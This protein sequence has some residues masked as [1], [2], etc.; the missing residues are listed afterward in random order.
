MDNA[1]G[2][3]RKPKIH[4]GD[5]AALP[6]SKGLASLVDLPIWS[7]WQAVE[8]EKDG[9]IRVMKPPKR[10]DGRFANPAH[11]ETFCGLGECLETYDKDQELPLEERKF[12]G[13]GLRMPEWLLAIDCDGCMEYER[14]DTL[15]PWVRA[16]I[17]RLRSYCEI[18]PSAR[19]IRIFVRHSGERFERTKFKI[20]EGQ[21]SIE[22]YY[23]SNHFVTVTNS[24]YPGT[25]ARIAE[26]RDEVISTYEELAKAQP[27]EPTA[28]VYS[29]SD[30][31]KKR[32]RPSNAQ[33]T[34]SRLEK[35]IQDGEFDKFPS[36]SEA[37][38]YVACELVRR[39]KSD[40]EI[41][42]ILTDPNNRISEP[43]REH[44][45]GPKDQARKEVESAH[46]QIRKAQEAVESALLEFV[47]YSPGNDFIYSKTGDHWAAIAVDNEVN[48]VGVISDSKGSQIRPSS[49]I[50]QNRS[51][52]TLAWAP[53]LPPLVDGK[54]MTQGG[55]YEAEGKKT[56][57]L[58]RPPQIRR[59]SGP[60]DR[61]LGLITD[62]YG[63]EATDR[64]TKYFAHRVQCPGSK[65]SF[66]L[67]LGGKPGI[68]KDTLISPLRSAVG[69]WNFNVISPKDLFEPWTD[70]LRSVVLLINEAA[71]QG[72]VNRFML[73]EH[74]KMIEAAPPDV[75]RVN[76]K[77]G[78]RHFI[79]N[80]CGVIITTNHRTSALYLPSDDR[81]HEV[82]WS[83]KEP[84]ELEP[85]WSTEYYGWYESGGYGAIA[86]YLAELDLSG[87]SV[88]ETPQK[89]PAFWEMVA[90][91]VSNEDSQLED[92]LD[93]LG[94]PDVLTVQM[95]ISKADLKFAAWLDDH[96]KNGRTIRHRLD[97]AGYGMLRNPWNK[98]G[99][100][101]VGSRTM[102]LYGK[103]SVDPAVLLEKARLL[104]ENSG[105]SAQELL[106]GVF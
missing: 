61:W 96:H 33:R 39:G 52:A 100:W 95:L 106:G 91:G 4:C 44:A 45:L 6:Q 43:T 93:D 104:Q 28:K 82:Y 86:N 18:T 72:E 77:Y 87:Y 66:A 35:T 68:G 20:P 46:R 14:P 42:A 56:W 74:L 13:V 62:R 9:K 92:V 94:H 76:P 3:S 17:D 78:A 60:V 98:K 69:E 55:W 63:E 85:K 101:R 15:N 36:R 48:Q 75:L 50:M 16:L 27:A 65:P 34:D 67:V 47:Y 22:I 103:R 89:T 29:F 11:P 25:L 2:E 31:A 70:Y 21:G 73:Y 97:E 51:V 30:Q 5:L 54:L 84:E 59:I 90:M 58:Y 1:Q 71:D 64:I 40:E 12:S 8:K 37:V 81:R 79:P 7:L 38:H 23:G 83:S 99:L 24:P 57:N 53:G 32:G 105:Q 19:G 102:T 10:P 80:V 88:K 49:W 26:A 41:I